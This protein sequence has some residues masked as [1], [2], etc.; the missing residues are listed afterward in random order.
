MKRDSL[1]LLGLALLGLLVAACTNPKKM[2]KL[3]SEVTTECNPQVLEAVAGKINATYTIKFPAKYFAKKAILEVTPVLVYAGGEVAGPVLTLQGE[4]VL[5]NNQVVSYE[6]GATISTPVTF[7][8]VEG[9]EKAVLELRAT[10]YNKSRLKKAVYPEPFKIA[11]GTN[12]TYML[13]KTNGIPSFEADEY[14]KIIPETREAQVLYLINKYDVRNNQLKTDEIKAF[15]QFLIDVQSDERRTLKSNDI[16]AYA[17][18]D[19]KEDLNDKL[20]DKRKQSAEKAF[21]K[22]INKKAKVDAPLNVKS[23]GE[24]WEGFQELVSKSNIEDKELILR[25]LSMY[26]DPNVREREIKNMSSVY[27]TLADKVL[28]ELRRARFIAN[29]EY[30][31][32]TDEELLQLINNDMDELDEEALLYAATLVKE[33]NV[34]LALYEK[35]ASKFNSNRAYN[36][37]AAIKLQEGKTGEAKSALNKMS[38]KTASYYNNMG[39]VAMQNKDWKAA[40]ENFAKSDLKET[41]LNNAALD[42]LNGNYDAAAAALA[43]SN[44]CNE[45]LAYIL[46]KQEAKASAILNCNCPCAAYKRAI[47]AAR[48]GDN[49]TAKKEI[50]AASKSEKLAKR[51]AMDIEFAKVN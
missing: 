4:S 17:S 3:A 36:N 31:N 37:I 23:I 29:I 6:N 30:Q 15:Q 43:G 41:K 51:A 46:T 47:I 14:Q 18:P 19:G 1:K 42:I 27:T 32:W 20:S 24:D 38:E 22:T 5:E 12:T 49:A 21:N 10:A 25:V 8:Y 39:V 7:E 50:E 44:S 11:D 45:A 13:V 26:S 16:I 35:A 33:N 2:A 9:M 48:K 40:A 28:P 34:K